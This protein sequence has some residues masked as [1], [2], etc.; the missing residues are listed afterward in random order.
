MKPVTYLSNLRIPSE[1]A[2]S[3]QIMKMCESMSYLGTNVNL[4]KPE[5]AS[6]LDN[7]YEDLFDYY[8]IEK[9]FE[10]TNLRYFDVNKYEKKIPHYFY[11]R[12][13]YINN[14]IWERYLINY[15]LRH[16]KNSVVFMRN[17]LHFAINLI[18]VN[19][20]PTIMEFHNMPPLRHIQKYKNLFKYSN[21][22][23][24]L[25]LTRGLA[26]D[27]SSELGIN[28]NDILVVPGA[29]DISKF[30]PTPV[31]SNKDKKLNIT[32]VGSLIKNRGVDL[33]LEAAKLL[34][35]YCI[36]II[37]GVG[38]ELSNAQNYLKKYKIRNVYLLG[39]KSQREIYNYYNLADILILPMS[40]KETHTQ[41][42]ASPNKLF[43]YMATGN[44]IIAA[45]LPSI[46]EILTDGE[47]SLLFEP[48]N[49][50]NLVHKIKLLSDNKTLKIK[51]SKN[52]RQIAES[53]TWDN[54]VQ[55]IYKHID[56][57]KI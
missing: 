9:K 29:V 48:D 32:Y 33:L 17:T 39:H 11:R 5:R 54:R 2:N 27:M 4:V 8:D 36:N 57:K 20:I 13:N 23:Y 26:E 40:G 50:L 51:L 21:N 22:I 7:E 34:P 25:A 16:H 24:P 47:N 52:A 42:Y 28:I 15:Y 38:Q 44:P 53:F 14:W 46:N 10:I 1:M 45:N 31:E 43:E 55:S 37:G 56:N 41:K 35:D 30:K 3:V 49:V 19:N 18:K 12:I 6:Q